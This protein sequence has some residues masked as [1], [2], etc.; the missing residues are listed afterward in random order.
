MLEGFVVSF[1][2]YAYLATVNHYENVSDITFLP[3]YVA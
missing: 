2:G 1:A 3:S